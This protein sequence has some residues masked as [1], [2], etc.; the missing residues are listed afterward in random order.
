V[1]IGRHADRD[2]EAAEKENR[3]MSFYLTHCRQYSIGSP[4]GLPSSA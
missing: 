3:V 2:A 1:A 4:C